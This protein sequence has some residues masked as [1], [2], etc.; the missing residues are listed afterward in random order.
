MTKN[1]KTIQSRFF[2]KV[3]E[4]KDGC[5]IWQGFINPKGYGHFLINCFNK[6]LA[7]Q[8]SYILFKG[9]IPKGC[10]VCHSCDIPSCVN[11]DHLWIGQP[12]DNTLD[13]VIKR[14]DSKRQLDEEKVKEIR[15]MVDKGIPYKKISEIY[16]VR[17]GTISDIKVRRTWKHVE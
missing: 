4:N 1:I 15:I 5:W 12:K 6:K 14:R 17:E 9:D 16:N 10:F 3:K 7:H 2:E 11:P 13:M 8:V